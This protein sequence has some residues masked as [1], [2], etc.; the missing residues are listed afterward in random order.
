MLHVLGCIFQQHD[1]RLVALA[2]VLC[3]LASWAAV[4]LASRAF[5]RSGWWRF[6]WTLAAGMVFGAGIWATHFI[7]MLAYQSGFSIGYRIDLT[8]LSVLVAMALST[9]GFWIMLRPRLNAVGGAIVGVAIGAMH[10]IGMSAL[11]GA[12]DVVWND[13]YVAASILVGVALSALA[14][15]VG[16]NLRGLS[17]RFSAFVLLTLAI[18]AMHFTAMSAVTLVPAWSSATGD[19]VMAPAILAVAVAAAGILIVALGV[20]AAMLD[21]H[22]WLRRQ[23][24]ADRLRAHIAELERTQSELEQTSHHLAQALEDAGAANRA[25]SLFLAAMSHELRTPLNAVIG[26]SELLSSEMFGPLGSDRYHEYADDILKS[27]KHLLA[28]IND[29]LDL[30]HLDTGDLKL[31]DDDVD[32]HELLEAAVG[33][34]RETAQQSGVTLKCDIA[35]NF[36]ILRADRRRLRQVLINLLSNAVK[37]TSYGGR[38]DV[39]AAWD[40]DGATL[41]I[42]DTGIGIAAGDI[43]KAFERFGQV[44]SRLSRRYEGVGLGLPLS[45]QLV[46]SHGGSLTLDSTPDVGTTITIVLPAE[47]FMPAMHY[48]QKAVA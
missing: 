41:R 15:W 9:L 19:V 2:A 40:S 12:F 7:A 25:K 23:T 30:S 16:M 34:M 14:A 33:V 38:V 39:T 21:G 6:G 8:A 13:Y 22:L 45:K 47:R 37:F 18:C 42:H 20:V 29:V 11:Q 1:L 36:P 24:E 5:V 44:D 4:T 3:A 43:P 31:A 32:L 46:E 10:F 27:G 35:A 48:E 28:L 17:G 26:F